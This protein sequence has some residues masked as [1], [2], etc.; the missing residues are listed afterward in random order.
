MSYDIDI[1]D[2]A[3]GS[4]VQ[5]EAKHGIRG[6][7]YVLG[8]TRDM[9]LNITYNYAKHFYR[10]LDAEQGIR[11]LY[12]K[13]VYETLVKLTEAAN[14]LQPDVH[15]DYWQPTEGNARAALLDLVMLGAQA[16]VVCPGAVWQGD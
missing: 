2:P 12:G 1:I 7:T 6:G 14:K 5:A 13:K 8:G 16:V 11:W 15:E 3:T 4:V 9:S 10:V